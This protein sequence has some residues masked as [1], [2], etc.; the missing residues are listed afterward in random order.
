[1]LTIKLSGS[2]ASSSC[3]TERFLGQLIGF[4]WLMLIEKKKSELLMHYLIVVVT[5]WSAQKSDHHDFV[6]I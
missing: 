2:A 4:S 5:L 1:M 3:I 6:D